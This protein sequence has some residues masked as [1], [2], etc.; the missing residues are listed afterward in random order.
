MAALTSYSAPPRPRSQTACAPAA[1]HANCWICGARALA[2]L[3]GSVLLENRNPQLL[4]DAPRS[5][6]WQPFGS[7]ARVADAPTTCRV[8]NIGRHSGHVRGGWLCERFE[9]ATI[10]RQISLSYHQYHCLPCPCFL[11]QVTSLRHLHMHLQIH[12]AGE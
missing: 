5:S 10:N 2:Y 9:I 1:V 12:V 11:L 4:C 6:V 7:S 3:S 8:P